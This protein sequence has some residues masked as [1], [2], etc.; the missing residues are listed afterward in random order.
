MELLSDAATPIVRFDGV[1]KEVYDNLITIDCDEM[2]D[3]IVDTPLRTRL[4]LTFFHGHNN[5]IFYGNLCRTSIV[6]DRKII[7][8]IPISSID[9]TSRRSSHRHTVYMDIKLHLVDD[10]NLAELVCMGQTE[11]I[12]V[13][14]VRFVSNSDLVMPENSQFDVEF[15]LYDKNFFKLPVTLLK[16]NKLPISSKY[17]FSYVFMFD[18]ANCKEEY[19]RLAYVFFENVMKS[20]QR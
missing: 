12:S 6:S 16:K 4:K 8:I 2:Y 11:D 7:E 3:F 14:A 10:N 1:F 15:N 18:F 17:D 13:D 9:V 20:Q 5:C 19:R